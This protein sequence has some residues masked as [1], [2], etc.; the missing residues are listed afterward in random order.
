[1]DILVGETGN[2]R[3][4]LVLGVSLTVGEEEG[5]EILPSRYR[6]T[7]WVNLDEMDTSMDQSF[8]LST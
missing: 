6:R 3:E 5:K 7:R 8:G 4:A 1:M 2:R